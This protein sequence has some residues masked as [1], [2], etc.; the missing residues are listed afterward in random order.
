MALGGRGADGS[1]RSWEAHGFGFDGA[2]GITVVAR[3]CLGVEGA[4]WLE[5]ARRLGGVRG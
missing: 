2:A 3:C 4:R 1:A 5:R